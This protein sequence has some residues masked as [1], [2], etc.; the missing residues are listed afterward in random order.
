MSTEKRRLNLDSYDFFAYLIP[1]VVVAAISVVS[2]TFWHKK[3]ISWLYHHVVR[4]KDYEYF[5][6]LIL[7][8]VG[9]YLVG[10]VVAT[11][12][13]ILY[14]RIFVK[15]IF[16]YPY[17]ALLSHPTRDIDGL[18]QNFYRTFVTTLFITL[19]SF[20]LM[21]IKHISVRATDVTLISTA[22]LF[23]ILVLGLTSY[24]LARYG[25]KS[26]QRVFFS[27]AKGYQTL[28]S[29]ILW[30]LSRPFRVVEILLCHLMGLN[31]KVPEPI[32]KRF[33]SEFKKRFKL[34][35]SEEISSEIHW[36]TY[37]YVCEKS[38]NLR[39]RLHKFLSLYGFTRNIAGAFIVSAFL[40]SLPA[41]LRGSAEHLAFV[42]II[43]FFTGIMISIRYYY[44]YSNYHSRSV[45]R[46]LLALADIN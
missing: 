40:V 34:T 8:L 32:R 31:T 41:S 23:V 29:N 16:G 33:Q 44:L 7:F 9:A 19:F 37:W 10:H 3:S 42:A 13:A 36:L 26:K 28:L 1:G 20:I 43:L 15:K 2:L 35:P 17:V 24:W 25:V 21:G 38:S 18:S 30:I 45:Y 46:G 14:D 12:S 22:C 11:I 5:S 27:V 39:E 4:I 6:L